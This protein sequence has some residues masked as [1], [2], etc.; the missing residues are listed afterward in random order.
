MKNCVKVKLPNLS[1][2]P[3]TNQVILGFSLKLLQFNNKIM[4]MYQ[5]KDKKLAKG[6]L[7][8]G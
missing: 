6:A 8:D 7:T 2:F 1:I 4:N 3:T 5:K